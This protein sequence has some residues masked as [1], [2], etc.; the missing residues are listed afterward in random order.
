MSEITSYIPTEK[1]S[2]KSFGIVFSIVFL[3]IDASLY[4]DKM[5]EIFL[6]IIFT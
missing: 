1:S 5:I 4:V 3:I 2:E 6:F